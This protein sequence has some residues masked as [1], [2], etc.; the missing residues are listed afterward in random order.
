MPKQAKIGLITGAARRVG[1]EIATLLH[2]SGINVIL[3][4]NHSAAEA[5]QLCDELNQKRNHSAT[6]FQADLTDLSACTSLV[7]NAA[8]TWGALDIVIN[9]ASR[10]YPTELGQVSEEQ[11]ND[12]INSNLKAPYF[13]CQAA[14]P[15]CCVK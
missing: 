7:Q 2:A 9:N 10:F 1:A 3:H 14:A 5:K 11:W 4:Y 8:E 6:I 12:L 15:F 13:L